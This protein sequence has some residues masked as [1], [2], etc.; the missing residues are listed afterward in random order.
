MLPQKSSIVHWS[1]IKWHNPNFY[2][3]RASYYFKRGKL[4]E[5]L[6]DVGRCIKID[7]MIPEFYITRGDIH[8]AQLKAEEAKN[9]FEFSK[10][11]N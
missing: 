8:F 7:S 4:D 2:N 11:V 6:N 5:A 9:D 1:D 10:V 3:E